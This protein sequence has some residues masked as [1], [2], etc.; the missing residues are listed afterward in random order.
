MSGDQGGC[1][2]PSM[3]AAGRP[4]IRAQG[5][6]AAPCRDREVLLHQ[7]GACMQ[8]GR[9]GSAHAARQR[10]AGGCKAGGG[11]QKRW[12]AAGTLRALEVAPVSPGM[13]PSS[14]AS[15]VV[16]SS[17][18]HALQRPCMRTIVRIATH[19][20]ALPTAL[21]PVLLACGDRQLAVT[22]TQRCQAAWKGAWGQG[23]RGRPKA[24]PVAVAAVLAA[25]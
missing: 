16:L 1:A 2:P 11:M 18:E 8:Q 17:R 21:G 10:E 3:P 13:R 24:A 12:G 6:N 15:A 7:L 19:A 25:L 5:F 20:H 22:G 9:A 14:A 4:P 23:S